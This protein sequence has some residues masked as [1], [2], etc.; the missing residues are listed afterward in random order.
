MV[1]VFDPVRTA[2]DA[3]PWSESPDAGY[4]AP[5]G[6]AG[7]VLLAGPTHTDGAEPLDEHLARVGPLPDLTGDQ[8]L[9]EVR[10]AGLVGR[11]GGGF[12][13][14]RKLEAA[15]ESGH[16]RVLIVNCS[17]SE[18]ASRKDRTLCSF[19][20]H[21]V[22]DGAALI[23]RVL[24]AD[25]VV[26][27]LHDS[28]ASML[29]ALWTAVAERTTL[30]DPRWNVSLGPGGYV[31]GEASAVARFVHEGTALPA[32]SSTPLARGGPSGR[33]TVVSNAE[34]AAHVS[35]IARLGAARWRAAGSRSCPGPLLL[36]LTG[37]VDMPGLVV[38]QVGSTTIGG[39]L[40]RA[41]VAE[42]PQAV[43]VGGY[44]G[45]WIRGEV[46]WHTLMDPEGL[47]ALGA[48]RGCGLLGVLPHGACG[49]AA[50]AR[51]VGYLAGESARQCGPC[52]RGLPL[53]A[54]GMVAL[55]E[56]ERGRRAV[57]SLHR[58]AAALPGSG[59]CSHPDGVARLVASAL[60]VFDQDA[61]RHRRGAACTGV[62]H[63]AVFPLGP[64]GAR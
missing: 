15:L 47:G 48:A 9:S 40:G 36:T 53:L 25:E 3:P 11:G 10:A 7:A 27:H 8:V 28:D 35:A 43:L 64:E 37:A 12:P 23:A 26:V 30:E 5:L 56:G 46:A 41:G 14:W 31:A 54:E 49:L 42:P 22:L 6:G 20:P 61:A 45:T 51:L 52:A 62:R 39:I 24:G 55:A 29:E 38:E 44:A 33:P 32:F 21:A 60:S 2:A 50:T 13:L 19:R 16:T 17:E 58:T 57:R 4:C 18:P 34:T 59:A 63:P 1:S